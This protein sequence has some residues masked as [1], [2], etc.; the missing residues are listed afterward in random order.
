MKQ[1]VKPKILFIAPLPP[2]FGGQAIMSEIVFRVLNPSFIVNV[3][4]EGSILI[5]VF[6]IF[7]IAFY[8]IFKV[9]D[10]IY[11]TCSRSKMGAIRDMVLLFL[12]RFLKIKTIN[13]LH[14]NEIRDILQPRW[15]ERIVVNAYQGI[16]TTIFVSQKQADEF[17]IRVPYMKNVVL[18]NCYDKVFDE[19]TWTQKKLKIKLGEVNILFISFLM[20]S[21]GIFIALE[22]FERLGIEYPHLRFNVAG[23]FRTDYLSSSL[24]VKTKFFKKWDDLITKFPGRFIYH[25]VVVGEQKRDLFLKNDILLFP[26]FFKTESFGLVLIEGM[27]SGN[28]VVASDFN[29]ISELV[30]EERGRLFPPK[31]INSAFL[32]IEHFIN[33]INKMREVQKNNII[34]S[35]TIYSQEKYENDISFIFENVL[36]KWQK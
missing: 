36:G 23:D 1:S 7:K 5:N 30:T 15:L 8:L 26:T 10:V 33:D 4:V 22:V 12:A 9:P 24:D 29:N 6:I 21:K 27:R 28:I 32:A 25:G 14:G 31:D 2:P 20:E 11:F 16:D 13:H 35:Q 3:N 18:P 34:F 19:I 17:P